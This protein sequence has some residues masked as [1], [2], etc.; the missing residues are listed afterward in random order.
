MSNQVPAGTFLGHPKGLFLLFATEMWERFSYYGMRA[1]LVLTLVASTSAMNPGF[2][3]STADALSIYGTFTGLCYLTPLIGG[4][5]ADNY[6][7]QR[8]SIIIGGLIMAAGQFC[9]A[10][11]IPHDIRL[12]YVGLG[13]IIV[14]NGFFKP[15]ISTMVGD[16][17]PTGDSRRDGAFTIFY[18]A[19]TPAR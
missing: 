16:L 15:N 5:I 19:S 4:W 7:G 13:L 1:L 14:G 12:F 18:M 10:A 11:A 3:W 8:K 6:L 17:Y 9:L 2:G